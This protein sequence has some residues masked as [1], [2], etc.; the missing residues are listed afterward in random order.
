MLLTLASAPGC[1]SE[2]PPVPVTLPAPL[3]PPGRPADRTASLDRALSAADL[4]PEAWDLVGEILADRAEWQAWAQALE[5][6]GRW[7]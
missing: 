7:R 2:P 5:A 6:A 1:C 4:S 3:L